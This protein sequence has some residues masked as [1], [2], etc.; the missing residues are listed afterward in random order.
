MSLLPLQMVGDLVPFRSDERKEREGKAERAHR[1]LRALKER[2]AN[3][4]ER[5]GEGRRSVGTNLKERATLKPRSRIV[6]LLM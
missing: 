5:V 4:Y 6:R 2:H 3:I 1:E